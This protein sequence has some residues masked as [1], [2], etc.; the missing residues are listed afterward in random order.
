MIRSQAHA[1]DAMTL[2]AAQVR[3]IDV[4]DVIAD[5]MEER[6]RH[7]RQEQRQE[8][9]RLSWPAVRQRLETKFSAP[10]EDLCVRLPDGDRGL[11]IY[12]TSECVRPGV[13]G[14]EL[15]AAIHDAPDHACESRHALV[16]IAAKPTLHAGSAPAATSS[17]GAM[18]FVDL[19]RHG[20]RLEV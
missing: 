10:F 16:M 9:S 14:A 4:I 15:H 1:S 5:L 20:Q 18:L 11:G 17:M 8:Q 3:M 2:R 6:P 19:C 12:I 7:A 13:H